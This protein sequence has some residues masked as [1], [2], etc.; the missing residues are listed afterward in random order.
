MLSYAKINKIE[1]K[2]K[3]SDFT[4]KELSAMVDITRIKNC[5]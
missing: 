2:N 1:E 4:I 5:L 3:V